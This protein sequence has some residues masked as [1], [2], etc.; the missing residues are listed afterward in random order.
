MISGKQI[1]DLIGNTPLIEVTRI[2]QK[3]EYDSF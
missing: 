1:T 3:K 2:I